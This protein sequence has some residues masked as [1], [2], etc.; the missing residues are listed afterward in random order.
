M[1]ILWE[2]P[3][4]TFEENIKGSIEEGK[5]ADLVVLSRNIFEIPAEEIK[6]VEVL[7][8]I[9]NGRIVYEK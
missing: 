2:E 3:I 4:P 1:A 5:Q 6:D 9:F 7:T 8:T